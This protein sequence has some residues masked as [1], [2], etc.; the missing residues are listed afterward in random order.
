MD[1]ESLTV[2][3]V[4]DTRDN[5]ITLKAFVTDAFPGS[6]VY[7]AQTGEEGI[8][9]ARAHD[10]DV[11]LL[12]IVMPGMDGFEVCRV[13]K[14]DETLKHI[15]VVFLTALR[16]DH[17]SRIRAL[18]AGGEAFISKPFDDA[19]FIAQIRAMVKIKAM[20]VLGRD[21]KKQL[22]GLVAQRT[23]ELEQELFERRAA[24]ER[25]RE[26][27]QALE[28]SRAEMLAL[29]EDLKNEVESRKKTEQA[30]RESEQFL[31]HVVEQIPDMIFVKDGVDFRF[32]R[33]NK[34]GEDLLGYPREELLGKNDYD[35]FPRDQADFFAEKDREVLMT[36]QLTDI[37]EE[38][39]RTR[40]RG[41]RILHTKK[42]PL[43]G[44]GGR[45]KYL[46]GIS[47]DITE[48]RRAE[49]QVLLANRKLALMNDVT[50]QDIQNK[51]T[52][53]RGYIEISRE[54]DLEKGLEAHLGKAEE[55]T[56]SIQRLIRKTKEYQQMGMETTR[57]VTLEPVIRREVSFI[58]G[59]P[60]FLLKTDLYGLA[61]WSDP[62]IDRVI[63]NLIDNSIRHG[64][65]ISR[66]S[67]SCHE[68]SGGL[69][70]VCE[71]D[72]AGVPSGEKAHIFERVVGG[73]GKFGLFF[74]REFLEMS[75]IGIVEN[76][77]PGKGARFEISV[78]KG[79]YR[80][81]GGDTA[82]RPQ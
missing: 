78:P 2:V 81:T 11:V 36:N 58:S 3:A 34:A 52:A 12:D 14:Q 47:E 75:G 66:V 70:L 32:V 44:E 33:F 18:E 41:E 56:G 9:L 10:P 23:R 72:G 76:G 77:V 5:L 40:V 53:L 63:S 64:G 16:A 67:F 8:R 15:P 71:D 46:L 27:N 57:W 30:L 61:I 39:V 28:Q 68:T 51:L 65:R 38:K 82:E 55:I 1:P 74:V 62:L 59:K 24:E 45:P 7:T 49:E 4:D 31:N 80:F 54:Q 43:A 26:T 73:N 13:L 42:I 22:A 25:L 29:L 17:K 50:F 21:E 35:L 37:P 48:R 60:D 20:N 19:E 79:L 69:V 6:R